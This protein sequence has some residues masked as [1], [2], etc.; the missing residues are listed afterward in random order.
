MGLIVNNRD[1]WGSV[2]RVLPKTEFGDL[3]YAWA[4]F[5]RVH[6]R[7]PSRT[8]LLFNDQIYNCKLAPEILHPLRCYSTDKEFFKKLVDTEVGSQY[9]VPTLAVFHSEADIDAFNFPNSFCAKPTHM[10]GEVAIVSN[11]AADR[12]RMKQ[13]L[14]MSHYPI[15]RERNYKYLTPKVIVE[16]L[17]FDQEDITDYRIFCYCGKPKLI[18]LDIGKYSNYTRAFFT[19]DWIKQDYSLGYPLHE[20]KID[21]PECLDEMLDVAASLSRELYFVRVDFYTN[22]KQFYL[23][24]LTHAHASASQRFIPAKA[25]KRAS[26][27]VFGS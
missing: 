17:I 3:I 5:V 10:S 26:E 12:V 25:E 1:F 21:R 8:R 23:G 24:E 16:P 18:C 14:H 11:G 22:G 15:S 20:G 6:R 9:S 7:I 2:S 4:K 19:P 13:W 27:T